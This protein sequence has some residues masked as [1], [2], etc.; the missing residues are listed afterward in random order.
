MINKFRSL[1]PDLQISFYYR[2]KTVKELY[3]HAAL[4]QALKSIDIKEVDRELSIYVSQEALR[5]LA[6]FSLR[7]EALFPIPSLLL[8]NPYLLG[9]YRLLLGFSQKEFYSKGPFGIFKSMEEKG[10][11]SKNAKL[12]LNE[13]CKSLIQSMELVVTEID[14]FS[15]PIIQELQLLT[16]GPLFRG[17][18]NNKYGQLATQKTF[19]LIKEIVRDY[20]LATTPLSIRIKN[21]SGRMVTI[22]FAADPDIEIIEELANS[23]RGLISMEIKGGLDI[24]NVHN[25]IGEAEKSHQKAR[26]RGYFEFMTILNVEVNYEA[27][28]FESPTTSHFYNLEKLMDKT[29]SEFFHFKDTLSSIMGIK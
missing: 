18:M 11:I 22:A 20:I 2:L 10:S 27:L 24:S 23:N 8:Q 4:K 15:L 12:S 14:E 26:K 9:Y 7:G 29:S 16:V 3:F 21:D 1:I 6:S 25:R 19:D 28:R 17:S 5:K 13:L